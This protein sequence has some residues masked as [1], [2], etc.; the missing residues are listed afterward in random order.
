MTFAT[1]QPMFCKTEFWVSVLAFR[2]LMC[3][4]LQFVLLNSLFCFTEVEFFFMLSLFCKHFSHFLRTKTQNLFQSPVFIFPL[5]RIWW[6]K[7]SFILNECV[8]S[9]CKIPFKFRLFFSI[10]LSLL[11]SSVTLTSHWLGSLF[12]NFV[13]LHAVCSIRRVEKECALFV[14]NAACHCKIYG[15]F[16]D[17]FIEFVW[18]ILSPFRFIRTCFLIFLFLGDFSSFVLLGSMFLVLLW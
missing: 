14:C 18:K 4:T 8:S 7:K 13:H 2:I 11:L 6:R 5:V 17:A 16:V 3:T 9:C 12:S 15:N 1:E 10:P